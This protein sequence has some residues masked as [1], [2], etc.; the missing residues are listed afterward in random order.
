MWKYTTPGIPD[1]RFCRGSLPMTKEEVRVVTLAKARLEPDS[2]VY[3]IGAGTGSL[4]VEAA[5]QAPRGKVYALE[6]E[7]EGIRLIK[8]NCSRFGAANVEVIQAEA[9]AGMEELPKA[10]AVLVGGSGG[11]LAEIITAASSS[12][13]KGGRIVINAVTLETLWAAQ[14]EL[15]E[16]CFDE[17]DIVSLAVTR[18]PRAGRS[19]MA[20]ALNPVFIISAALR[21]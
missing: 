11:K 17:L 8:L 6:R 15:E 14:K 5:L 1:A 2:I 19:F 4:T 21:S 13:V 18:W 3:D 10:Q 20:K 12:L 16:N 7:A 9:P